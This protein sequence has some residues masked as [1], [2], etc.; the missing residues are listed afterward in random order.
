MQDVGFGCTYS[1]NISDNLLK[2]ENQT[3]GQRLDIIPACFS[4]SSEI[5][6]ARSQTIASWRLYHDNVEHAADIS[7]RVNLR[8]MV[9][10]VW[11]RL[12]VL[13]ESMNVEEPT[14]MA[15]MLI[16][17][18]ASGHSRQEIRQ[19]VEISRRW[20]TNVRNGSFV[21]GDNEELRSRSSSTHICNVGV[22][23][24]L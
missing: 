13:H 11:L 17:G 12:C 3:S 4:R 9:R 6:P 1:H 8:T 22:T 14:M 18:N 15:S 7:V 24:D 2:F 20:S 10:I 21:D 19:F 23:T 16:R 5:W